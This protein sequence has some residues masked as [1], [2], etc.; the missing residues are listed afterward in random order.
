[1]IGYRSRFLYV[2]KFA[3]FSQLVSE[4]QTG[5][6]GHSGAALEVKSEEHFV[7]WLL[8]NCCGLL[9]RDGVCLC[10]SYKVVRSD[11]R[12]YELISYQILTRGMGLECLSPPARV[13]QHKLFKVWLCSCMGIGCFCLAQVTIDI[14][15][16]I[17]GHLSVSYPSN[18]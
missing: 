11:Y 12:L 3:H 6:P 9:V 14:E 17:G 15:Q 8:C 1:M 13:V 16:G 10:P 7:G 18:S 2:E 5:A 4:T